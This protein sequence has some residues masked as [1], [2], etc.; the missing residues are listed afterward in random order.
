MTA[1]TLNLQKELDFARELMAACARITRSV[2]ETHIVSQS[3]ADRSPVTIADYAV[4]AY[5]A[6]AIRAQ[7]PAD[8]L[9]GEESSSNLL[10]DEELLSGVTT[11]VQALLPDASTRQVCEWIDEGKGHSA[12]AARF[13]VIDPVDGTKGFLRRM[14][15]VTALALVVDGQVVLGVLGCPNISLYHYTGGI[16]F[17]SLSQGAFWQPFEFPKRKFRIH[18]SSQSSLDQARLVRSFEDAHTN[19]TEIETFTRLSNNQVEPVRMDSQAKY[20]LL[21]SAQADLLL[22]LPPE[23]NPDYRENIWDQAPAYRII[24]EA[25]GQ[26]TD[27]QG[28]PLD[29]SAGAKMIHNQ[30]IVA[31]NGHLH[32]QTLHI[33]EKIRT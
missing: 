21:A 7:F 3:K 14:Q 33:L 18:A 26:M 1:S 17:A 4:Q 19:I 23:N 27:A 2:Q 22:R 12:G 31:S 5:V 24:L 8:I 11:Q 29:F 9:V 28:K 13:W 6:Q 10:Q 32:A 16:V 20:T 15:Y 25:G 30:G